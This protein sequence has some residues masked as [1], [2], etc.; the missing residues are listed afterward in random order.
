MEENPGPGD[1][2][3]GPGDPPPGE[4]ESMG[5]A[6]T[7]GSAGALAQVVREFAYDDAGRMRQV[8]HDGVVAMD[9]LYNGKGER[10][11][12]AS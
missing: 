6:S 4:T 1:P 7:D 5:V 9:Y 10:V 11:I 12:L 8:R 3:P 2:G